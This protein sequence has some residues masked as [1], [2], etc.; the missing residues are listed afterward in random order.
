MLIRQPQLMQ[1]VL[2][3]SAAGAFLGVLHA[4][5]KKPDEDRNNGDHDQKLHERK[6][7]KRT[8][9]SCPPWPFL[10]RGLP[11]ARFLVATPRMS[12]HDTYFA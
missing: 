7:G 10:A 1:V 5:K 6:S 9:Q 12:W 3:L 4:R 11:D 8:F 2:A